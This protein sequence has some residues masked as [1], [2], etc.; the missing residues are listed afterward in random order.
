MPGS[1]KGNMTPDTGSL[2]YPAGMR[3]LLVEWA[4]D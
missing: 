2:K 3:L 1:T 4:G